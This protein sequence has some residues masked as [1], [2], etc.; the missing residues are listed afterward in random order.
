M[1]TQRG[2]NFEYHIRSSG[3]STHRSIVRNNRQNER[4]ANVAGHAKSSCRQ[5][6][7]AA[8]GRWRYTHHAKRGLGSTLISQRRMITTN[9]NS[10]QGIQYYFVNNLTQ[11]VDARPDITMHQLSLGMTVKEL[12][13]ISIGIIAIVAAP[14]MQTIATLVE[15]IILSSGELDGTSDAGDFPTKQGFEIVKP[16]VGLWS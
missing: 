13:T 14:A 16:Q 3:I 12:P 10:I 8:R 4:I 5:Y 9:R 15:H 7:L 6:R 11:V 2:L 1:P